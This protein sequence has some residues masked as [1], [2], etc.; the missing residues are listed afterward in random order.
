MPDAGV[1]PVPWTESMQD[2]I[3]AKPCCLSNETVAIPATLSLITLVIPSPTEKSWTK[4]SIDSFVML[5]DKSFVTTS[6]IGS[7]LAKDLAEGGLSTGL[8]LSNSG[9]RL[10]TFWLYLR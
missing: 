5:L 3:P 4:V 10:T 7:L 2:T 8:S 1:Y 6:P 9:K